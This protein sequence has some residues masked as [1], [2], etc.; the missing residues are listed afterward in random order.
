M[1]GPII[2]RIF[3]AHWQ[4]GVQ[5]FYFV[6][7]EIKAAADALKIELPGNLGD[8]IYTFRFRSDFPQRIRDVTPEGMAWRIEL[9]GRSRYRFVL[10][11]ESRIV[12]RAELVEIKIPDATPELISLYALDDEQALLAIVRYNRLVDIF[13]GVTTYSLQNHLRTSVV[14]VGQIEIDELYVAVDKHGA[15][16]VIPVQAKGGTDQIS[17]VQTMQDLRACAE[18]F[19]SAKCRP[20]SVQFLASNVIAM[21]ELTEMDGEIKVVDERHYRLVPASDFELKAE[22]LSF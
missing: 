13:L 3:F 9:A 20:L 17:T 18:K 19:P 15:H 21:F 2:E 8:V 11:K 12:P 22:D 1:Y 7:P 4:E 5:E 16:Y 14:G 10:G 6:R